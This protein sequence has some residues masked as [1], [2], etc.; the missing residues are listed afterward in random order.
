MLEL[1]KKAGIASGLVALIVLAVTVVPIVY[2][3]KYTKEQNERITNL[4][5]RLEAVESKQK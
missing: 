4:E 2:Q 5:K 1:L 3:Y